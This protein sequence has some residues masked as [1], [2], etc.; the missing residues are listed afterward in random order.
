[1]KKLFSLALLL[2]A[3]VQGTWA[4]LPD[5]DGG[6]GTAYNPYLISNADQWN[7]LSYDMAADGDYYGVFFQLNADI[8]VSTMIGTQDNMFD[9]NFNGNG[10][11]LTFNYNTAEQYC[12]PFRY[13]NGASFSNLT[14]K[15]TIYT[16]NKFAAGIAGEARGVNAFSNCISNIA[17]NST[18]DGD[19]T[20]GGF[21]ANIQ[22]GSTSFNNCAFTGSFTGSSTD[23]WGG[24]VGWTE[25]DN[26]ASV[27]FKNCLFYPNPQNGDSSESATFSRGRDNNTKNITIVDSYYIIALGTTQGNQ[28]YLT[29]DGS[30]STPLVGKTIAGINFFVEIDY[31]CQVTASDITTTSATFNW[32]TME[33]CTYQLLYR[34]INVKYTT[35]FEEEE[36]GNWKTID[37][38]GDG[39]NWALT[40]DDARTGELCATSLSYA[41]GN[42][43]YPNNWLISPQVDLGSSLELWVGG[44][45]EKFSDEHFAIYLSTTGNEVNDFTTVLLPET[46][47]TYGYTKYT[48]DLSEF[49]GQKGYI[50]IRHFNCSDVWRIVVDD[51]IIKDYDEDWT[52]VDNATSGI[53]VT[54]LRPNTLYEYMVAY[55]FGDRTYTSPIGTLTTVDDNL[56]PFDLN[57]TNVTSNTAT[58]GWNG[59]SDNYNLR[60]LGL[61]VKTAKVTL[62]IPSPVWGDFDN[63]GYQ[64]LLDADHNAYGSVFAETGALTSSGDVSDET[65]A[66]F[67]YKIPE[68][69]DGALTTNNMILKGSI[70]IEIPAGI[71]DWCI[72][73]PTPEDRMWIAS[74]NGNIGGRADDFEFEPGRHYTFTV[75]AY[76][77]GDRVDLTV[78]L[79]DESE[80]TTINGISN[81][82]Y[83]LSDLEPNTY[84][85]VQVQSAKDNQPSE[86]TLTTFTTADATSIGLLDNADNSQV[87]AANVNNDCNVTLVDRTLWKDGSWNTLCLPFDVKSF[88]GTPL[89]GATVMELGNSDGCD[90]RF[91]EASGTLYLDFVEAEEIEAGHAYIVKW[92]ATDPDYI[93][94]PVFTGVKIE[95]E[96]PAGQCAPSQDGYVTFVGTYNPVTIGE[97]GDPTILYLGSDNT[98]YYPSKAM[99]INSFRAYFQLNNGLTAGETTSS[100][101][102][103]KAFKLNFGDEETGIREITTP[104][105]HSNLSNFYYTLDGHRLNTEPTTKGLY[106]HNGQ[107]VLIK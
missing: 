21:V 103:I 46:V 28:G 14:V 50:A 15:G 19:G 61:P 25:S 84:Y 13:I 35:S 51:F 32:S 29:D 79:M 64:M 9:G 5:F 42:A 80:F 75:T 12:A 59:Y 33:G 77:S 85:I 94:N 74:Q 101:T 39:S 48:A 78:E 93:E 97:Q 45:H 67:E 82:S 23:S 99:T 18:V 88:A 70:T 71:Y 106:I 40:N 91:D 98:L 62:N 73:N 54:D 96:D 69:A 92:A 37:D 6:D 83:T 43:F 57:V 30:S 100:G 104:S 4:E 107:K 105:N 2:C 27:R 31:A 3:A 95:N 81:T 72:T 56:A 63:T 10:H 36:F 11:T 102:A 65:Y 58:I 55:T 90:T 26:A 44:T 1:M 24:F 20:H 16:S 87:I 8:T 89:E 53:T 52:T 22:D 41:N 47:T 86:W 68:N 17:I 49:D 38:D 60:Y 7:Q 66:N 76:E 34:A